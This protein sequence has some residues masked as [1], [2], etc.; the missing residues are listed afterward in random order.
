VYG[1]DHSPPSS[2]EVKK[3]G[4]IPPFPH[5]SS[6]HSAELIKHRDEFAELIKH[7]D[8]FTFFALAEFPI[9]SVV[10]VY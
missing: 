1:A 5:M 4:T 2:A 8:E 10:L 6:W 9:F 3:G 7:R